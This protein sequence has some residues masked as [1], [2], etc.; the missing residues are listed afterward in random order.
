MPLLAP[1][2]AY[3]SSVSLGVSLAWVTDIDLMCSCLCTGQ[4]LKL[5]K[6]ANETILQE[7]CE[8]LR[9]SETCPYAERKKT[10]IPRKCGEIVWFGL[11][12]LA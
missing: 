6:V 12:Y 11:E 10:K 2:S 1:I 8:G 9:A 4:P 7:K 5:G 3:A